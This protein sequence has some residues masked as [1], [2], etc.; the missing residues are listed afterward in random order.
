MFRI[1][2]CREFLVD[3]TGNTCSELMRHHIAKHWEIIYFII[4]TKLS[5]IKPEWLN[6]R[7][8]H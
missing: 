1:C 5:L 6:G 7:A 2:C 8:H 3:G 4:S